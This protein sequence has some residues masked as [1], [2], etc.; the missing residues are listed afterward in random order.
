MLDKRSFTS[1]IPNA[2]NTAVGTTYKDSH[3]HAY[4]R[5]H[6]QRRGAMDKSAYRAYRQSE[7]TTY[8]KIARDKAMRSGISL[9]M[10]HRHC[11]V[12]CVSKKISTFF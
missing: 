7:I 3:A 5:I 8:E 9:G 2:K 1:R 11:S 10:Q 12:V 6:T 4:T